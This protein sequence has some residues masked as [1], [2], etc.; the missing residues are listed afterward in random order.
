MSTKTEKC[1]AILVLFFYSKL[2][3]ICTFH[4]IRLIVSKV[5]RKVRLASEQQER[6]KINYCAPNRFADEFWDQINEISFELRMGTIFLLMIFAVLLHYLSSRKGNFSC[7]SF[8]ADLVAW[9]NC[10]DH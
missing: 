2:V 10:E 1:L 8:A 6:N 5:I 4:A 9:Q 3:H 7:L